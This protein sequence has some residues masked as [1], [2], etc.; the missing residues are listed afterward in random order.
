MQLRFGLLILA[1]VTIF[2]A[3]A[4]AC[5]WKVKAGN[6][7]EGKTREF[8]FIAGKDIEERLGEFDCIIKSPEKAETQ[9]SENPDR[10][11]AKLEV[12]AASCT[13]AKYKVMNVVTSRDSRPFDSM[14]SLFEYSNGKSSRWDLYVWCE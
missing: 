7:S 8:M 5:T 4:M 6:V 10:Y 9:Y 13:F 2:Q 11:K 14:L 12:V 3:T 1:S